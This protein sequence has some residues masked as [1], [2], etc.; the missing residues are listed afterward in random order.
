[1]RFSSFRLHIFLFSFFFFSLGFSAF[2]VKSLITVNT[3]WKGGLSGM[4][5]RN[6]IRVLVPYSKTF[7]FLD[8]AQQKGITYDL[9]VEFEDFLNKKFKRKNIQIQIVIIPTRR[10]KLI[11]GLVNGIGDIAAGNLTI[12]TE[13][14]KEVDFSAPL[15]KDVSEI[16]VFG[17]N[18]PKI[19]SF[20]QMNFYVRKS[21]SYYQSIVKINRE[22]LKLGKQ[23]IRVTLA[24]ELLEDEDIL[25]MMNAGIV[26]MTVIDSHKGKFWE[27]IFKKLNFDFDI[28]L[29]TKGEI[30][31]AFR[32]DSPALRKVVDEFIKEHK[33]GT[34][35]GNILFK[36][37]LENTEWITNSLETE[38]IKR[39]NETKGLFQKY[40]A[41][42]NFEWLFI[43]AQ[44][45]QESKINQDLVSSA[46]AVGVMQLLPSTAAD[47]CVNIP[48]IHK[49]E[50][51]IEAGTKYMNYLR[52]NYY[53]NDSID[54]QNKIFFTLASY[55]AGPGRINNLRREAEK[56]GLDKN[57]WF[58][59]V[60]IIASKRIGRETVRYVSN[61]YKYY[62]A[63]TAIADE[64]K[65]KNSIIKNYIKEDKK[66]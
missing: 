5:K 63:Y 41:L 16:V 37:Y 66:F 56:S 10:D 54:D 32:K 47:T 44:A 18:Q 38:N 13:R 26:P 50:S 52:N 43:I 3:P 53:N 62:L 25:E 14:E 11:E 61:I 40:S 21:S 19:K 46:G 24:D 27:Q 31:W 8:G 35:I 30:A 51:N 64:E 4:L 60:E 65:K 28:K 42:Y 9:L 22:L 48:D 2:G 49:I 34:L 57:V 23:P 15:I 39:V 1:M 58:Q 29:R 12:T 6:F 36:R 17:V 7:Y 20:D 55:N 45:Y 33:K 59:N